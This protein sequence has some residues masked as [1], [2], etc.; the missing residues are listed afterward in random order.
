MSYFGNA[1]IPCA[2]LP[3]MAANKF[4]HSMHLVKHLLDLSARGDAYLEDA[5][6]T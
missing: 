2:P 3:A 1:T 6:H 5:T 4:E